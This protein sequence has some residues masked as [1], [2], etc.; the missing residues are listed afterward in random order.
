MNSFIYSL[1]PLSALIVGGLIGLGIYGV[2]REVMMLAR[3][4]IPSMQP[5]ALVDP[6]VVLAK[7]RRGDRE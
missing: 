3:A 6:Q 7:L 1:D 2:Y 4:C 5:K